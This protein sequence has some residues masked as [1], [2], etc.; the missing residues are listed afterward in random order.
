MRFQRRSRPE[1]LSA[2]ALSDKRLLRT[3]RCAGGLQAARS[4]AMPPGFLEEDCG[5]SVSGRMTA[6]S[7]QAVLFSIFVVSGALCFG[8]GLF[9]VWVAGQGTLHRVW[10]SSMMVAAFSLLSMS[11]VRIRSDTV[12][13]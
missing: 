5:L 11:A 10:I 7:I 4:L 2:C 13:G 12:D 8:I 9:I 1:L 3:S 6:R